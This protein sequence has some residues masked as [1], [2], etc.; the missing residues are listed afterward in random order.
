M[1]GKQGW[2]FQT[3]P[4]ALVTKIFKARYFPRGD[5]LSAAKGHGP[6]Y[7]WQSIRRSQSVVHRGSRWRLGDG[8]KVSVWGDQWLRDDANLS[9]ETEKDDELNGLK[10]CDLLIPGLFEWDQELLE[11]LFEPREVQA[12][13]D[14][15]L[16]VGGTTDKRIWHYDKKGIYSVKSAY[17]VLTS[18]INLRPD[19]T[20]D[21]A[22]PQVWNLT[23]PP[24]IKTFLWR[25]ARSVIPTRAVLRQRHIAVPASCGVCAGDPEYYNHL[26]FDCSFAEDCWESA[27]LS[28]WVN[29]IKLNAHSFDDRLVAFLR[30]PSEDCR[31]KAATVLWG[32]WKERNRRVWTNEACTARTATKLALDDIA[33]WKAAQTPAPILN[34]QPRPACEKWH[35]PPSGSMKCN[36]DVGFLASENK[37]GMGIVLRDSEGRVHGYKQWHGIGQWTP[38]EGEAAALL[39]AMRWVTEEGHNDVIFESDADVIRHALADTS[40]D[41]SEFG[42]LIAQCRDILRS[43]PH[44]RVQVVRRNRNQVAHLLARQSFSLDVALTSHSPPIGMDNIL[45]DVCFNSNH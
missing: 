30:H 10:V 12:I 16:G 25:L 41:L 3:Q 4:D 15:P 13:I 27:S 19:L 17:R 20:V 5:F 29:Q 24:R 37:M 18:Y 28:N 31:A 11:G 23:A 32:I 22:W 26:F 39:T 42:C 33:N 43:F 6:S 21:G 36:S 1:L 44:F 14:I 34:Q 7:V 2:K 9:I 38:R 45:Y 35:A 40:E 8:S